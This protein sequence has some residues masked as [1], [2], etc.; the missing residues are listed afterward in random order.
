[1]STEG[2]GARIEVR[3]LT[4]SFGTVRAVDDLAFVVEPG[5]VTGF[6]GPN[7]AGKT[8]T[9]RM[10]LGLVT[11]DA[12]SATIGGRRYVELPDPAR[13]VGAA[14]EASSFHPGRRARDHLRIICRSAGLP[15]GRADEVLTQVGLADAASRRVG[16]FSMG[17]RQRLALAAALVGNPQVLVLDEPANGLDPEGIAWLRG[18]LRF[19][20]DQ[21]RTILVSSHVLSEVAQT[22]DQVVIIARGQLVRQSRL[23]D[24]TVADGVVRVRTPHVGRLRRALS[25]QGFV[26]EFG[27]E[28]DVVLVSGTDSATVGR[29]A[30]REEVELH[31]LTPQR[32]DLEQVFLELTAQ[33]GAQ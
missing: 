30:L 29:I 6:L 18:F 1:V 32:S 33:A 7:G 15:E 4:K 5:T 2:G 3:G 17:M 21:G 25:D 24:L 13:T 16:G 19:L 26:A 8:T 9:L 11:P 28:P 27:N 14:L 12:G 10:L 20:A 31:E 22:V 23:T